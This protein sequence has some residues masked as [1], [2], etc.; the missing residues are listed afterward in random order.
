MEI[1]FQDN[2]HDGTSDAIFRKSIKPETDSFGVFIEDKWGQTPG[3]FIWYKSG[4]DL[5]DSILN[6]MLAYFENE[7]D[8]DYYRDADELKKFL[9]ATDEVKEIAEGMPDVF[10]DYEILWS[11]QPIDLLTGESKFQNRFRKGFIEYL[12]DNEEV[13]FKKISDLEIIKDKHHNAEGNSGS[14]EFYKQIMSLP[15][16]TELTEY[17]IKYLREYED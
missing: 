17:L 4:Y 11:G 9:E 12:E 2:E 13:Y 10:F 14:D 8:E 15:I 1:K 16:S 7:R 5:K 3:N 6:A